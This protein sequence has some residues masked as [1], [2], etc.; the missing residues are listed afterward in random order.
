[1]RNRLRGAVPVSAVV[2]LGLAVW[3]SV[4]ALKSNEP[5]V[6]VHNDPP[7]ERAEF[8]EALRYREETGKWPCPESGRPPQQEQE[9][10]QVQEGVSDLVYRAGPDDYDCPAQDGQR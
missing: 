6:T 5:G 3:P 2:L 10:V 4:E 7:E 1:M 8:R 9:Q